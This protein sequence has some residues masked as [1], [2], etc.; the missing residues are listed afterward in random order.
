MEHEDLQEV[1][2]LRDIL[3]RDVDPL[4]DKTQATGLRVVMETSTMD[5]APVGKDLQETGSDLP[6]E[7]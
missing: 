6:D 3:I 7:V 2:L 5:I 4:P 1:T